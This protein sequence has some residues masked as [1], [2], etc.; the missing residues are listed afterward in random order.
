[1]T[2]RNREPYRRRRQVMCPVCPTTAALVAAGVT[3]TGGMTAL[4]VSRVRSRTTGTKERN[5]ENPKSHLPTNTHLIVS[6][7]EWEAARQ[8]FLVKEKA[9]VS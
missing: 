6:P 7:H 3:S 5:M 4:V 1:V 8:Q 2:A 9:A